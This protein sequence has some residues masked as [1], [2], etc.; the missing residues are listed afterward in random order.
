MAEIR[1]W[2]DDALAVGSVKEYRDFFNRAYCFDFSGITL[3]F[4]KAL[5]SIN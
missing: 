2:G 3:D 5:L 4:F 1:K